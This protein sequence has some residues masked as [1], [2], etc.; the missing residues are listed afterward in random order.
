MI[1][2]SILRG[3]MNNPFS[4]R[5]EMGVRKRVFFLLVVV[6]VP[7]LFLQGFTFYKWYRESKKA[8]MQA[9]LELARTVSKTFDAFINDVLHT[10]L[11]V[12]LAATAS[13]PP[14]NDSF[15][16]IL[17][18]AE[19]TNPMLRSFTWISPAGVSLVTTDTAMENQR[20]RGLALFPR[21]VSGE[22]YGVS[23]L[24]VSPYT[25]E[26]IFVIGRG[27][28]DG[29]GNL[30]GI[31]SCV[32]LV[33]KLDHLLAIQRT[34][35]T[36]ISLLDSK[37]NHVYRY[38][39]MKHAPERLNR[40]KRQPI[41]QGALE[42]KEAAA[43]VYGPSGEVRLG[44]FVPIPS[45]G[46]VA[47]SSRAKHE[48]I[49]SI[50]RTLLPHA[51][52]MLLVTLAAFMAAV[53]LSRPISMSIRRLQDHAAS[54]GQGEVER[55]ETIHGPLEI[56]NLSES[57]NDMAE[58]IRS[59]EEALRESEQKFRA[60]FE[61]SPE[62]VFLTRPD[63][64]V[65]AAN[66]VACTMLGFSEEEIRRLGRSGILDLDDPRL[67]AGLEDRR[68]AGHVKAQELTAIRKG[69]ERFP[70]EV[71]SVILPGEPPQSFVIMRDISE[72]KKAEHSLQEREETSRRSLAQLRSV[73]NIMSEGVL[74]LDGKGRF[75]L[76]NPAMIRLA[77]WDE[78][79][80][81]WKEYMGRIEMRELS[82]QLLPFEQWPASRAL[83]GESIRD[84][85]YKV[86]RF[87]TG[88]DYVALYS[89]TPAFN[90][91]GGVALVV[92]TVRDIT[93]RKRDEEELHQAK[94]ELERRV[95]ERTAELELRNR[96][97][98]DF[99]FA[100]AHDLQEPLRKIQTFSDLFAIKCFDSVSEQGHDYIKRMHDTA[101]RMRQ[102]LDSLMKYSRLTSTTEPFA[103]VDLN[104]IARD[105]VSDLEL[106]IRDTGAV[107]EIGELPEAKADAA[108]MR[109][110]FQNLLGNA[111]KFRR[112][113]IQP[114]VSI[115]A[116]CSPQN[117]QCEIRFNDNGIGF[118]E[119]YLDR[120]FKPFHR[121]HGKDEYDGVGMGLAICSKVIEHH[122]GTITA[123]STPG[124][125]S[126]FI[127][128]LPWHLK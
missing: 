58:T 1:W 81:T 107:V 18:A 69:G 6:F 102:V 113:G 29:Q 40:L 127:V 96:E 89:G 54:F 75:L 43:E 76:V 31:I 37:G 97:L 26:N 120:I 30:L 41:I 33:D 27:V 59:R 77:G 23:D 118:E 72:R 53:A 7:L 61:N 42:G 22:E 24:Y 126:T 87:D 111:L 35:N 100:A 90:D 70:V 38:P 105:A 45:I 64:S 32:C 4:L 124:K 12:G 73:L 94:E 74:I 116:D 121:L 20:I 71:D 104:E 34:K 115:Q 44:A 98:Q 28:R 62:A 49:G 48:V 36:G 3:Q 101:T 91:E 14:S 17:Q 85:E 88:K 109:Q 84:L 119:K 15:R 39:S 103:Q 79:P 67:S 93:A 128:T 57:F 11:A 80:K 19:D 82:G 46:W 123:K 83:R 2:L 60:L 13:P 47:A 50:T 112:E 51:V 9:N 66:P 125:G 65:A 99:T 10:Q 122:R 117:D 5:S 92:V 55:F 108:Q 16:R 63:G 8:E 25:G 86:H 56:K 78:A 52:F 95:R 106:Q 68:R 110:L 21:I 114:M